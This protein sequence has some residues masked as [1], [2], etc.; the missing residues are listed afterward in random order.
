MDGRIKA[1]IPGDQFH[2]WTIIKESPDRYYRGLSYVCKCECGTI[3]TVAKQSL[4]SNKSKSCGCAK[5]TQ[6][7]LSHTPE[8]TVW[9]SMIHRCTNPNHSSYKDYGDRE[10]TVC[11]EW[12]GAMGFIRFLNDMGERPSMAHTLDRI[13]NNKGYYKENCV[14]NTLSK[15]NYNRRSVSDLSWYKTSDLICEAKRRCLI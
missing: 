6:N 4:T 10:I 5:N 12:L 1:I 11:E 13:N 3:R 9:N 14:W 7:G 15:Q 8:Y 2:K